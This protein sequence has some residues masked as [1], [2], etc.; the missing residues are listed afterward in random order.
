MKYWNKTK[1][2]REQSWV[3][4]EIDYESAGVPWETLKLLCQ[5]DSST[6][7]FYSGCYSRR[8]WYFENP[9]DALV[10]KLKYGYKS[11]V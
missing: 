4:V 9:E 5:R 10:F 3:V 2:Y 6:S 1:K 7:R 11:H 8:L